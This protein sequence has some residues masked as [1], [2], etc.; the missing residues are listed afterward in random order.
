[1]SKVTISQV[2][3]IL[4]KHREITPAVL[5]EV[6]EEL[7]EA[8]QPAADEDIKPPAGKKQFVLLT[9]I[10]TDF[11]WVFQMN[12]N[13]S[14]G[15]LIDRIN[16]TAHDFNASKRGRLLPVKSHGEAMESIPRKFWKENDLHVKTKVAV[17]MLK[18]DNKLSE[19]PTA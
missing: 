8:T 5:R 10:N 13:D 1:M 14:P 6:V 4:K 19:P 2:A 17:A 15:S 3:E 16:K 18:T 7:N 9:G 11:G 12:E